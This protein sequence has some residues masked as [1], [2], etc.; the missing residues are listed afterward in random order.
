MVGAA[1]PQEA[2]EQTSLTGT[3]RRERAKCCQVPQWQEWLLPYPSCDRSP[4]GR[5]AF[6][7][8]LWRETV[9]ARRACP[10]T[11]AFTISFRK[12]STAAP[13]CLCCC[14]FSIIRTGSHEKE[15]RQLSTS[16]P[17]FGLVPRTWTYIGQV[18]H[19]LETSLRWNGQSSPL[20]AMGFC[21]GQSF[22]AI[23]T[24]A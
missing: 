11:F 20:A 10:A 3:E 12:L 15:Q 9:D 5:I 19:T 2:R 22:V 16:S 6:G 23:I 18:W 24:S 17:V 21:I 1:T 4:G 8:S 13:V 7:P 14:E